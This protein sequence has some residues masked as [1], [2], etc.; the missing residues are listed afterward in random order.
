MGRLSLP[1][2]LLATAPRRTIPLADMPP[3]AAALIQRLVLATAV[4]LAGLAALALTLWLVPAPRAEPDLVRLLRGMVLIKGLIGLA[5]GA[6][7]YWRLGRPIAGPVATGY[8]GALCLS[9]AGLGWLWGLHLMLIGALLFYGGLVGIY[10]VARHDRLVS[11]AR[12][13]AGAS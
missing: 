4:P 11:A 12:S 1:P 8:I 13:S 5:A 9:S 3:D 6:L 10:L 2:E 7:V